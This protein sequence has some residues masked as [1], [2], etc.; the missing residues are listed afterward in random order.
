[1]A[2][3]PVAEVKDDFQNEAD[4]LRTDVHN[5]YAFVEAQRFTQSFASFTVEEAMDQFVERMVGK[6]TQT[7]PNAVNRVKNVLARVEAA[8]EKIKAMPP[9]A[10]RQSSQNSD[11]NTPAQ[12][13]ESDDAPLA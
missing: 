6:D 13:V 11:V 12:P 10:F 5:A 8:V 3:Q 4:K 9:E 7:R 1:M 2:N